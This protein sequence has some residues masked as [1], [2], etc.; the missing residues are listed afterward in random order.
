MHRCNRRKGDRAVH[1]RQKY[2]HTTCPF[3]EIDGKKSIT[4]EGF[5]EG[6]KIATKFQDENEKDMYQEMYCYTY[7]NAC[8]IRKQLEK[9][10]MEKKSD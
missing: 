8:P 1:D 5:I 3:Y 6:T 2:I 7:P 10:Y 9:K 4:C